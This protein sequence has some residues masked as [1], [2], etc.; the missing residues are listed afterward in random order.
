MYERNRPVVENGWCSV[1]WL[2]SLTMSSPEP[3]ATTRSVVAGTTCP[4]AE[5][6][7]P[8]EPMDTATIALASTDPATFVDSFDALPTISPV[9]AAVCPSN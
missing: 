4:F 6:V 9:S 5:T 2:R 8:L 1:T 7:S 3:L